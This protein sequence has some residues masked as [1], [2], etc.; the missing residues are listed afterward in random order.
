[1]GK[2]RPPARPPYLEEGGSAPAHAAGAREDQL[3]AHRVALKPEALRPGQP[4]YPQA[5][6]PSGW[7]ARLRGAGGGG[8]GGPCFLS[9]VNGALWLFLLS[10]IYILQR[11]WSPGAL[12]EGRVSDADRGPR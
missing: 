3:G 11:S 6:M 8:A 1:M 10:H 12:T 5:S 9:S 2:S 7:V 4:W